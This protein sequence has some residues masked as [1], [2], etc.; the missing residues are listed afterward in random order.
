MLNPLLEVNEPEDVPIKDE[1]S[2][3]SDEIEQSVCESKTD[4]G[5]NG[6]LI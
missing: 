1:V 2:T 3:L 4:C 6:M 5:G